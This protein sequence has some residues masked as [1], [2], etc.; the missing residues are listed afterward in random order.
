MFEEFPEIETENLILRQ[1]QLSDAEDVFNFYSDQEV[2]KYHDVEAFTSI[3]RTE[4]LIKRWQQGFQNQQRM[5]WGITE[6]QNNIIIG[7]CGYSFSKN[8]LCAEIGYEL[9]KK[10]WRQGIM[11]EAIRNIMKFGF[12]KMEVN[13]IQA[14]VMLENT[15]SMNLLLKLGFQ[16]EGILR[17]YGFWKRQFHDIKMFSLLKK[18]SPLLFSMSDALQ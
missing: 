16:E 17:E 7:T 5:R 2:V 3:E 13:R 14:T 15:P 4:S 1:I 6:K 11:L 18:D 8:Y 10:Y 12:Q 9:A